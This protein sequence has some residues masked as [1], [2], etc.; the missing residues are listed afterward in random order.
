MNWF[1]KLFGQ[2]AKSHDKEEA[3]TPP[4]TPVAPTATASV[5][6]VSSPT[7]VKE[8]VA[9]TSVSMSEARA[10]ANKLGLLSP[11][12]VAAAL[13]LGQKP[14]STIYVNGTIT[15]VCA[16][17]LPLTVGMTPGW[18]GGG[19]G[20][21]CPDCGARIAIMEKLSDN[22]AVVVASIEAV[23][24]QYQSS[25]ISLILAGFSEK[26]KEDE[27]KPASLK[28]TATTGICDWCSAS[29]LSKHDSLLRAFMQTQFDSAKPDWIGLERMSSRLPEG[30]MRHVVWLNMGC[31]CQGKKRWR[32]AARCFTLSLCEYYKYTDWLDC[33]SGSWSIVELAQKSEP[34]EVISIS[35]PPD[36][37]AALGEKLR[38]R[39]NN[40]SSRGNEAIGVSAELNRTIVSMLSETFTDWPNK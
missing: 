4:A 30:W 22:T 19:P 21:S 31:S 36:R 29:D 26:Q 7:K 25:N 35:L 13:H 32:E 28:E 39:K 12:A 9:N 24:R 34:W 10:M 2:E 16:K 27:V 11:G 33:R 15:C 3:K 20:V 38:G 23:K 14:T 17:S 37:A 1:R 8:P 40:L 5:G 6:K 18:S